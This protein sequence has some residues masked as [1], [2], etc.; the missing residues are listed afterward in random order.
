MS[1]KKKLLI[2]VVFASLI[3]VFFGYFVYQEVQR[4]SLAVTKAEVA[5]KILQERIYRRTL[6]LEYFTHSGE[7]AREQ[8]ELLSEKTEEGKAKEI[9]FFNTPAEREAIDKIHEST[10]LIN[11]LFQLLVTHRENLLLRDTEEGLLIN[12]Y[13]KLLVAQIETESLLNTQGAQALVAMSLESIKNAQRDFLLLIALSFPTLISLFFFSFFFFNRSVARP[14]GVLMDATRRFTKGDMGGRVGITSNDEIGE[15]GAAFNEM[16]SRLEE[17][18]LGMEEKV[19]QRTH[20]LEK[21]RDELSRLTERF[22]FATRSAGIGVWEW[23]VVSNEL[24]WDDQMYILYGI[25]KEDFSEAYEAWTKILHPDDKERQE[26]E[27]KLALEGERDF[28]TTFRVVWPNGKVHNLRGFA[29][30]DR[31][32]E[33]KP[34][35]LVGVNWDVT[36]EMEIDKAKS[37][38]VSLASH[39]LRTPLSTINWYAEMLESGD[40]GPLNKKQLEFLNEIYVGSRRMVELVNA[41]L[42]V[43][44]LELGKLAVNP[45]PTDIPKLARAVIRELKPLVKENELVITEK[46]EKELP[47]ANVDPKLISIVFQNLLTNSVKYTKKGGNI[48]VSIELKKAGGKINGRSIPS[49]SFLITVKD[50]GIGIPKSQRDAVFTKLFRADNARERDQDGTGLGLYIIKEIID[51]AKGAVWY[52]SEE[53]VGTA[54]YVLLPLAGML[55]STGKTTLK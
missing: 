11:S 20:D 29:A 4:V 33:G 48:D 49:D 50:S 17:M 18:Y 53:G 9:S 32:T 40:A 7:R 52:D 1:I 5:E 34:L 39:Q 51:L 28:N 24:T 43:S 30:V 2:S 37:E 6:L 16:A 35:R 36:K 22:V 44:R 55:E 42:N 38:F 19:R 14:L 26:K 13:E 41:L 3:F 23:D 10:D 47:K 27:V 15:L 25:K 21:S 45:S 31:D 46:Y 8:W 54:F 12:E